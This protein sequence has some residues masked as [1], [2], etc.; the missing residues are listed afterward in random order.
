MSAF[1]G[2]VS[3]LTASLSAEVQ[4]SEPAFVQRLCRHLPEKGCF[5]FR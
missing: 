4:L 5:P 2:A 1:I 3:I